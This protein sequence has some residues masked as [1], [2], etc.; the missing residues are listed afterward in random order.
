MSVVSRGFAFLCGLGACLL[1]CASE[2]EAANEPSARNLAS[3]GTRV[4]TERRSVADLA[5]TERS[6]QRAARY[7]AD[8]SVSLYVALFEVPFDFERFVGGD[9]EALVEERLA[10]FASERAAVEDEVRRLCGE[11]INVL[12]AGDPALAVQIPAGQ[13]AAL[14]RHE[15]VRYVELGP[16]PDDGATCVLRSIDACEADPDCVL[17]EPRGVCSGEHSA[18]FCG[19]RPQGC[20]SA[21]FCARD[22]E[23][24]GWVFPSLCGQGEALALGWSVTSSCKCLDHEESSSDGGMP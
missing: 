8:R 15:E 14:A 18:V 23:G 6:I 22:P 3:D 12:W 9:V 10:G 24:Q 21:V 20:S 7:P 1:A 17:Y 19:R 5:Y 4:A 13:I 16:Q 2:P 11:V